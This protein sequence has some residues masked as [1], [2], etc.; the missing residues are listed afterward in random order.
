MIAAM[1]IL[2]GLI[3]SMLPAQHHRSANSTSWT[4]RDASVALPS[5]QLILVKSSTI[6]V[7]FASR[8]VA[9]FDLEMAG[10]GIFIAVGY[11]MFTR[12]APSDV[13]VQVAPSVAGSRDDVGLFE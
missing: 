5:T 4:A 3:A 13:G 11:V 12:A 8:L 6:S 2:S 10:L 7:Q 1:R 9:P